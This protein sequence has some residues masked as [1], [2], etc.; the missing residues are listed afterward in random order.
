MLRHR[1]CAALLA[2]LGMIVPLGV[3]SSSPAVAMDVLSAAPQVDPPGAE[4]GETA[5]LLLDNVVMIGASATAGFGVQMRFEHDGRNA[6][7]PVN[8]STVFDAA[9]REPFNATH[10]F[11][12]TLFFTAP[13]VFG[14]NSVNRAQELKPTLLVGIDFLFWYGYGNMGSHATI[15]SR[16]AARLEMLER[17]LALLER[18]DCPIILG[19]FPDMSPAVGRMISPSQ[20]PELETL[21]KLNRRVREWVDA[22]DQV[23]LY[24]LA[25]IVQRMRAGEDMTLGGYTWTG[26]LAR[27]LVQSDELHPTVDGLI[28]LSQLLVDVLE[29]FEPGSTQ[30]RFE[31]DRERVR[32]RLIERLRPRPRV[33]QP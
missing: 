15:E 3:A 16:E 33:L 20:M 13:N 5:S 4:N 9:R 2:L 10:G 26:E 11:G 22:R 19:D 18:F 28:A 25:D 6:S 7:R 14:P 30:D 24:P 17:G 21:E 32:A 1:P 12:S 29:S 27:G 23:R 8:F 31:L